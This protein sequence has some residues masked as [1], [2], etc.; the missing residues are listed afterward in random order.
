MT[1]DMMAAMSLTA[2]MTGRLMIRTSTMVF[3]L[4]LAWTVRT[5]WRVCLL[6]SFANR[7]GLTVY[8]RDLSPKMYDTSPL[9]E[10]T[11]APFLL[12]VTIDPFR[13]IWMLMLL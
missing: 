3:V 4:A 13:V 5:N 11:L 10:S 2:L 6:E 9:T 1:D 8:Y 7:R 12:N